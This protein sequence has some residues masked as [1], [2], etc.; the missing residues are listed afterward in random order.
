VLPSLSRMARDTALSSVSAGFVATL[1]AFTSTIALV[2][3]AARMLGAT[4]EQ[5]S[6]WVLALG[7]G[8]GVGS[9]GLSLWLRAPCW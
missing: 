1:V 5:L 6:S 4:P 8:M 9:I 7:M 2:F 3:H